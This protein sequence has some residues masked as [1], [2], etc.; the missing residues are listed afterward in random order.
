MG[1]VKHL[2]KYIW[3][4]KQAHSLQLYLYNIENLLLYINT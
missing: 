4:A 2:N 1:K 3:F